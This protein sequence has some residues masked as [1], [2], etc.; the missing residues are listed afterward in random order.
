MYLDV[1]LLVGPLYVNKTLIKNIEEIEKEMA[2]Q[3]G[4]W[5]KKGG[6]SRPE[7]CHPLRKVGR[8]GIRNGL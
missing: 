2:E 4:G 5:V 1:F 8:M 6:A 3:N 7:H